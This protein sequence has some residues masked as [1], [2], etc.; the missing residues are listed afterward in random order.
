VPNFQPYTGKTKQEKN[1][2]GFSN[3]LNMA[4]TI[5]EMHQEYKMRR[6]QQELQD[7]EMEI[8]K[9]ELEARLGTGK[10]ENIQAGTM[11]GPSPIMGEDGQVQN[12]EEVLFGGEATPATITPET[13]EQNMRRIGIDRY[14][15]LNP[16]QY[17]GI[18]ENGSQIPLPPNVKPFNLPVKKVSEEDKTME[19][20]NAKIKAEKPKAEGSLNNTLREYDAMI[21]EAEA[22]RDDKSLGYATG[23]FSSAG[24]IPG[25]GSKRVAARMETLKAKTLLNVL[26]SLKE[27]SKTGASGFGQ[28][29]ELEGENIKNSVS[30]F[31]LN[32][33]TPDVKASLDRF[34]TEMVSKRDNLVSTFNDTYGSYGGEKKQTADPLGLR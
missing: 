11:T 2:E 16:T 14:K 6:K 19:K 21:K 30:T 31:D 33:S 17:Y 24:K 20:L 12:P 25:T 8:K 28:L 7:M 10:Y 13:P 23:L 3:A 15:V 5:P 32:Q 29:S 27:L 18:G 9:R 26:S 22:I 1:I 34:I 4:Q